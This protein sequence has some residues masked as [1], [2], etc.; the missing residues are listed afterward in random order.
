MKVSIVFNGPLESLWNLFKVNESKES[1]DMDINMLLK[2][3][4]SL[5]LLFTH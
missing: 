3:L 5:I 4:P 2:F 1:I